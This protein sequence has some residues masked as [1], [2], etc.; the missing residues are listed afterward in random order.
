MGNTGCPPHFLS[1]YYF[2]DIGPLM[3]LQ[4]P[5]SSVLVCQPLLAIPLSQPPCIPGLVLLMHPATPKAG[6]MKLGLR[7]AQEILD[8]FT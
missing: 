5:E 1:Y 8:Q 3:S 4:L 7:F 6:D 2:C